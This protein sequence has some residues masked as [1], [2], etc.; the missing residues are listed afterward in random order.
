MKRILVILMIFLFVFAGSASASEIDLTSM[1]FDELVEL[2]DQI[3]Q[4]MRAIYPEYDYI[5][6]EGNYFVGIDLPAGKVML[7]RLSTDDTSLDDVLFYDENGEKV[8]REW[9][10]SKYTRK[11][12]VIA[13]GQE[14]HLIEGGPI[15]V[16]Y[17]QD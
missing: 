17:L 14:L 11:R 4:Q 13:E 16:Q 2:R 7:Y 1:T 15:G 10:T 5:L 12:C 6:T 3:D 9:T 8:G